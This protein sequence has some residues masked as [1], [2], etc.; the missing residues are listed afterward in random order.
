MLDSLRGYTYKIMRRKDR[1]SDHPRPVSNP[2]D[3]IAELRS[4]VARLQV[5]LLDA[6]HDIRKLIEHEK[7]QAPRV[8][9]ASKELNVRPMFMIISYAFGTAIPEDVVA[10]M[11]GKPFVIL[12]VVGVHYACL[13]VQDYAADRYASITDKSGRN[14]PRGGWFILL[15]IFAYLLSYSFTWFAGIIIQ[16]EARNWHMDGPFPAAPIVNTIVYL[17]AITAILV[18]SGGVDGIPSRFAS[19]RVRDR[20]PARRDAF[21]VEEETTA[22]HDHVSAEDDLEEEEESAIMGE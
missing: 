17:F 15:N 19:A 22:H 16:I 5:E 7:N 3:S 13:Y 1:I 2:H 20:H 8:Y 11:N 4:E 10:R 12:A 18:A 6:K 21:S 9:E 14:P